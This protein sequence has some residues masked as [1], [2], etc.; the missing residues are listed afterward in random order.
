MTNSLNQQTFEQF[1]LHL[2]Q[3]GYFIL[4]SNEQNHL[5]VSS[6]SVIAISVQDNYVTNFIFCLDINDNSQENVGVLNQLKDVGLL[7][8]CQ[9]GEKLAFFIKP[10]QLGQLDNNEHK[11]YCDNLYDNFQFP[12]KCYEKLICV[13][14]LSATQVSYVNLDYVEQIDF[15]LCTDFYYDYDNKSASLAH[16]FFTIH[17]KKIYFDC[18]TVSYKNFSRKLHAVIIFKNNFGKMLC[19][20]GSEF[21]ALMR[22]QLHDCKYIIKTDTYKFFWYY[23]NM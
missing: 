3:D 5:Q 22:K 17:C 20:I 16:A 10:F 2:N 18:K 12:V 6:K 11:I 21:C 1:T 9:Y 19:N 8:N 13:N 14:N 23:L 15:Q 7:H 4:K